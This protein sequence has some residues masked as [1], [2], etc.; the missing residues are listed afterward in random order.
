MERTQ[1]KKIPY[2][3]W[4]VLAL[5][6]TETIS[7]GIVYYAYSVLITSLEAEFGWSRSVVTGAFSLG[8]LVSGVMAIP[9]GIW[10]DR[11]SARGIMTLGSIAAAIFMFALSRVQTVTQLYLI[12]IGLGIAAAAVLYEPA[13]VVIAKWFEEQRRTAL[14]IVTI[15]AGFASTIFLPLTAWLLQLY[16]WRQAIVWLAIILATTTIPLHFFILRAPPKKA[17]KSPANQREDA[18]QAHIPIKSILRQAA[19]W[20]LAISF[21]LGSMA[22]IGMRVHFIPYM[23]DRGFEP[24]FAAWIAGMIG[25]F[26]VLGRLIFAPSGRKIS[27]WMMVAILFVG[28]GIAIGILLLVPTT[29]GVWLFVICFGAV[30]GATTLARPALLADRYGSA[31]YGRISSIQYLFQ[32]V[33]STSAPFGVALL[34]T[35]FSNNYSP[36]ILI[37]V[38]LSFLAAG[39]VLFVRSN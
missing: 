12:W 14:T 1:I 17:E 30:R 6:I 27:A 39:S 37:L 19:F 9:V 15:A 33:A 5:A 35:L 18:A 38:V 26:Q 34:Y 7:W 28:Q 23:A 20:G 29:L 10:L 24:S 3:W 2:G 13:F 31:Q 32:T 21:A 8:L 16:G 4:I 22:S 11:H 36:V 25:A